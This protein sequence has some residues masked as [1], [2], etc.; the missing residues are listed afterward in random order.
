[1]TF[2]TLLL[3][4]LSHWQYQWH[5]QTFFG[6]T[7]THIE[8]TKVTPWLAP[9]REI[10]NC[11]P[12]DTLKIH[13]LAWS[14]LRY[15]RWGTQLCVS[16]FLSIRPSVCLSVAHHI[17]GTV[18]HLFIMFGTHAW[19]DDISRLLFRFFFLKFSFF[20][21][22][23]INPEQQI[24]SMMCHISGTIKHMIMFLGTLV[25]NDDISRCFFHCF[26]IFIFWAV[27]G[28]K[29]KSIAQNENNNYLSCTISLRQ[30]SGWSWFLLHLC[31][32][33]FRDVRRVKW[34]KITQDDKKI[35]SVALHILGTIH[36][37]IL[38]NDTHM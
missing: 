23:K 19:N 28:V 2:S 6:H 35:L 9:S 18:H 13:S 3:W 36:H 25:L 7:S 16:V 4:L 37:V 26:E 33:I 8:P 34:Q 29:R 5:I 38:I 22:S 11:V 27:R 31:K 14:V 10:S 12:P 30:Y 21:N 24:I 15:F 32:F 1:M 20:G 17:S